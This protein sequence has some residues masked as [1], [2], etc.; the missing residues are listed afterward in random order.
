MLL[1]KKY[2]SEF[3]F[4][5]LSNNSKDTFL[6]VS[7]TSNVIPLAVAK[8]HFAESTKLLFISSFRRSQDLD[9]SLINKSCY[10]KVK[11]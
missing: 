6:N 9:N 7:Q 5:L 1:D 11:R 4:K 8:Q 10:E 3:Q 2:N